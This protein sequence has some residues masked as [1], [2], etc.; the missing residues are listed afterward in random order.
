MANRIGGI[1]ARRRR[2]IVDG[3]SEALRYLDTVA[4]DKRRAVILI[5]DNIEG[6]SHTRVDDAITF[7][8]ESEAVVYSVKVGAG[9]GGIFSGPGIPGLPMP[10][11][12]PGT[13]GGDPVKVLTKETGGEIFDASSGISITTALTSAVDR[14]SSI[15]AELCSC[16]R[17]LT[18]EQGRLPSH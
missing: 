8:L 14:L 7:A 6:D 1:T 17:C 2:A 4:P 15:H 10:R 12:R 13:S 9:N 3:G 11:R 5:S 18:L 16:S